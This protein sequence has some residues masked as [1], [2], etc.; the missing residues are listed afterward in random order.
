M[1]GK[2][3]PIS[4]FAIASQNLNQSQSQN[5][6]QTQTQTQT[7]AQ[8][9]E[10]HVSNMTSLGKMSAQ[11]RAPA[12]NGTG[13]SLSK[14]AHMSTAAST[15][16]S[17]SGSNSSSNLKAF[18]LAPSSMTNVTGG[19]LPKEW[20]QASDGT[21][22][23]TNSNLDCDQDQDHDP[24]HDQDIIVPDQISDGSQ[25]DTSLQMRSFA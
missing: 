2:Y 16:A 4:K 1:A 19:E 15:S 18:K 7:I 21:L 14:D 20:F 24:D 23:L 9:G 17:V 22:D 13:G 25:P 3:V 11:N 10:V 12:G 5:Q 8:V 6:N